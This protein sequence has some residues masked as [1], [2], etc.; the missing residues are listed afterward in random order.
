MK[1]FVGF[2]DGEHCSCAIWT[3]Y[4][5][6]VPNR[7]EFAPVGSQNLLSGTLF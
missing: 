4:I 5:V 7:G 6:H 3:D 2:K 1:G